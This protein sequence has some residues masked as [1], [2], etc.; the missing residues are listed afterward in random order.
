MAVIWSSKHSNRIALEITF[1]HA[2]IVFF[3]K[4]C[5]SDLK[6]KMGTQFPLSRYCYLKN[7]SWSEHKCESMEGCHT[8]IVPADGTCLLNSGVV[9]M[10][11]T[12]FQKEVIFYCIFFIESVERCSFPKFSIAPLSASETLLCSPCPSAGTIAMVSCQF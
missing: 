11:C 7:V 12:G 5:V 3:K 1:L 8:F 4:K 10:T 2:V 6:K 9:H